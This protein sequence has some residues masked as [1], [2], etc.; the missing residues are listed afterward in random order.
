MSDAWLIIAI[1][2]FAFVLWVSTGG[3]TRPISFSGPFITPITDVGDVQEGYGGSN[4]WYVDDSNAS[5]WSTR[6]I[7]GRFEGVLDDDGDIGA[8]QKTTSRVSIVGGDSNPTASDVRRERIILRARGGTANISGWRLVSTRSEASAT[9][10]RSDEGDD[11][12]LS[13]GE[14]AVITTGASSKIDAAGRVN[15]TWRIYLGRDDDLWR[16]RSDTIEL[17]DA[18]GRVVDTYSY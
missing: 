4:E 15:G 16:N 13:S 9:I 3:P 11:I 10:P 2:V 14:E 8:S 18:S 12:V 6:T 7:F 5:F 17:I 1:F